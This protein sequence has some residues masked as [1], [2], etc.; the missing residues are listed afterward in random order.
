MEY[1]EVVF[2][3]VTFLLGVSR[4]NIP[5][6]SEQIKITT[7]VNISTSSRSSGLAASPRRRVQA[8]RLLF[9]WNQ[10]E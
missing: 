9:G 8:E 6:N 2:K 5:N 10:N 1:V 3:G 7:E 4:E